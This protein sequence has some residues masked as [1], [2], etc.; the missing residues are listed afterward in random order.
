MAFLTTEDN[1]PRILTRGTTQKFRIG[2]FTDGS[3]TTPLIPKDP[4]LF[5]SYE[6]LD[7]NGVTI[8]SGV[9]QQDGGPGEYSTSW[10]VLNDALL[11]NPN[12][13]YEFKSSIITNTNEQAE[14]TH[15]FD[16][17]DNEVTAD[18]D[19]SQ[20]IIVLAETGLRLTIRCTSRI[21][22]EN[23][24]ALSLQVVVGNTA[25]NKFLN[26]APQ[27]TGNKVTLE[28]GQILETV[29][30]DS[31]V[32]SYDI[33]ENLF[34]GNCQFVSLWNIRQDLSAHPEIQF[35]LIRSVTG[36]ILNCSVQLRQLID[37]LAT[38][39]IEVDGFVLFGWRGLFVK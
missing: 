28:D 33:P 34:K 7:I 13:R 15:E 4:L 23:D 39:S 22:L 9:M 29:D 11:T 10:T 6:I 2:F 3:K 17:V 27:Q 21:D 19:R 31:F 1:V 5:P 24:G 30:G 37:K 35:Q 16:V 12:Q 14:I 32:Y 18:E 25:Q 38:F 20:C 8:Q 26:I 36:Q